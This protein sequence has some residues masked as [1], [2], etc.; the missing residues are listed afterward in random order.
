MENRQLHK[1][2]VPSVRVVTKDE[3]VL[4]IGIRL[5]LGATR[6]AVHR[7]VL[8]EVGALAALGAAIGLAVFAAASRVLRSQLFDVTPTDPPAI[9]AATLVLAV[10][11]CA[12]GAGA[13]TLRP[14]N[15]PVPC[16]CV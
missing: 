13:F 1:S 12:A 3:A 8:G 7:T 14:R 10:V 16:W 2:G 15:R 9:V 5:A 11:A 6:T 4:G